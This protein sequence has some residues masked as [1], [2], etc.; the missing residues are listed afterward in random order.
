VVTDGVW[1]CGCEDGKIYVMREESEFPETYLEGHS[2]V[3]KT[4]KAIN[5]LIF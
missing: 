4:T 3:Y 1:A 5:E 2:G